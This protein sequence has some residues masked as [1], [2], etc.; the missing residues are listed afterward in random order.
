MA[1]R[2]RKPWQ[3]PG[4]PPE[5]EEAKNFPD[6]LAQKIMEIIGIEDLGKERLFGDPATRLTEPFHRFKNDPA[7]F[8]RRHQINPRSSS[9]RF[10]PFENIP[11]INP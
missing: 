8:I 9:W 5:R 4:S 1:C 6:F 7:L 2:C 3:S 11:E 10:F